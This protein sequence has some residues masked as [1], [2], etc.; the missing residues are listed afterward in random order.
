M[1]RFEEDVKIKSSLVALELLKHSGHDGSRETRFV[2]DKRVGLG[3]HAGGR[4][5]LQRRSI[6]LAFLTAPN[7]QHVAGNRDVHGGGEEI[8]SVCVNRKPTSRV[9][10]VAGF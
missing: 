3:G 4:C 7:H 2:P 10:Q 9:K 6:A 1:S 8:D 5:F